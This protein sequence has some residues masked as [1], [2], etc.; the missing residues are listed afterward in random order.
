MKE[1]TK[2]QSALLAIGAFLATNLKWVVGFLKF[3]KFGTTLISMVISLGAY[4]M[5]YGWKFA[6]ALV[7]LI[8]VH[9]M[10]HL[11]AAK[12]KGIKTSPAIF[13]PFAGALI[14]MKE[15]PRDAETESYLAYGGPLAGLISFLPAIPLYW[16]TNDPFWGLVI[17]LGAM[18]N[19]FNLLPISPLDGGRIVSVLS[20]K[21]WFF[22]LLAL[23]GMLFFSPDPLMFLIFII[24]LFTW[25]GRIRETYRY[26]V[27]SYEK[28]QLESFMEEVRT[29]PTLYSLADKRAELQFQLPSHKSEKR[30][31][32]IP[33]LQDE[34]RLA[35]EKQ[36]IS[37][38]YATLKWEL[39]HQWER[40]PVHYLDGNPLQPIPS[41]ILEEAAAEAQNHLKQVNEQMHRLSTYYESS[42]STK[43]KVLIAYVGLILI[44]SLFF[45]YGNGIMDLHQDSLRR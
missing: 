1:K 5:F 27:L 19:L 10:G 39:L 28:Q 37:A 30:P 8:F 35:F 38:K 7:Y 12:Q 9:E 11:I 36:K 34:K 45:L 3:S 21:L 41:P 43:W 33:F 18:I 25:W 31:F 32:T 26:R 40:M 44:L 16:W 2:I 4:A 17:Y 6:V 23:G 20:T 22:G 13:I 24:G 15:Q 42:T 29:W 14:S